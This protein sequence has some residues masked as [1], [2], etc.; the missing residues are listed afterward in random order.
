MAILNVPSQT[1]TAGVHTLGPV[2][3]SAGQHDLIAQMV[4]PEDWTTGAAGRTLDVKFQMSNDGGTTWLDSQE[5]TFT[6]PEID[7]RGNLPS[8]AAGSSPS[9]P[10]AQYRLVANF[11][12]AIT[13]GFTI[14]FT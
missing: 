3:R 9:S 7:R 13:C 11:G 10:A 4:G 2:S 8:F 1:F 5:T 14:T 12:A 6:S